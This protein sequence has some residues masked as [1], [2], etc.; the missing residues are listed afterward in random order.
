M[1]ARRIS[2]GLRLGALVLA[3]A[4]ANAIAQPQQQQLQVEQGT[5]ATKIVAVEEGRLFTESAGVLV[6]TEDSLLE[7]G[8]AELRGEA[9]LNVLAPGMTVRILAVQGRG[10]DR[11]VQRL[12]L[13]VQ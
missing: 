6:F 10:E 13:E 8:D 5:L 12:R 4:V 7:S 9:A 11:V 2:N 1:I 3:L